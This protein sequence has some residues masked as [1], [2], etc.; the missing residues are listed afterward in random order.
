[1]TS[2]T[3]PLGGKTLREQSRPIRV[4]VVDDHPLLRDGIAALISGEPDITLAATCSGGGE[5]IEKFRTLRP[6]VT[7]M[8]LQ[9]PEMSGLDAIVA[10]RGEFPDARII[11][12]T[13]HAG[14]V[15]IVRAL[16]AGASG[17]LLK[18]L[19]HKDLLDTIRSVHAGRKTMSPE[20]SI[21]L[22][23][24]ATDD[25]LTPAE[26]EV[27]GLIAAGNSNKQIAD[28]L[29]ITEDTVK[30]RVRSILSKLS[31]NDRTHAATIG[32]KRGIIQL[33]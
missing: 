3:A 31:A 2:R 22:A 32:L 20:V 16:K 14:D 8:D 6:D 5:A 23:T 15:Q 13:N 30:G 1:M 4:L 11:V 28:K 25:L 26:I 17:Y 24:H 18:N 19:V 10:I 21:E 27:L 33:S 29:R 7:L 12:L 9:M